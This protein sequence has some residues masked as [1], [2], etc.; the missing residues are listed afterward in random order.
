MGFSAVQRVIGFLIAGS[1]LM[2]LP[3][4]LVSMF[5]SDGTVGL[6]LLSAG[7]LLSLG[8]MIYFPV[9]KA[10]QELRLRDGFLIVVCAWLALVLVGALPFVLLTSPDLSYVDAVFESMSGLTTT[11]ATIVTDID[12]LPRAVLYYRQQLQWLGGMGIIVLA[13]AILPMLRI[14]GMQL[15]RAETP[16]PMKDAKLTPR[17]TETAKALWLIY[18]GITVTCVFAYWLA[19]MKLF[20]AVGHAFSTVA[21]GGF[22]TH[23]DSLA[24]W[25]NPTVEIVAIVFMAIAGIN[26]A[27]HFTAWRRATTQPYFMDPELKVYA[28]LLIAFAIIVSFALY[29]TGTYDTLAASFRYGIFQVISSMTTTG[30]TTAP[31]YSWGGFIPVLLMLLAFIG[32][33]A[34]STAG[35]M[36][37][38]RI[39]LLY[40]Q[41]IREVQRLIHPHAVIPVKIGG[42]KTSDTVISAVWGFFFLYIANFAVMTIL[43]TATG[44]DA[45]TAYSTVGAC[46]TNLGPALGDAGV[47]YAGLND[48]A[49]VILSFAMLLGRL[50]IYTLLVLLTPAFWRD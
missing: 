38:I 16:G 36:K 44:L 9:R 32:G 17:I 48:V 35:G 1:S 43:L 33:C 21:I 34:G 7:M 45:E 25:N 31:F 28:S 4:V 41:S 23:N 39:I 37:V 6:F 42:Q 40:R 19:G 13:V 15:Y 5:Y 2:M 49:K 3:P 20:D 29:V 10:R 18:V 30:F 12:A 24:F 22:S 14:G 26:F 27:L 46:I 47:N 11:G 8:L 50:E